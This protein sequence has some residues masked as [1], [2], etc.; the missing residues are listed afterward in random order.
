MT[1]IAAALPAAPDIHSNELGVRA[2]N[3]AGTVGFQTDR[4]AWLNDARPDEFKRT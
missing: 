1:D 3:R 4:A 2:D